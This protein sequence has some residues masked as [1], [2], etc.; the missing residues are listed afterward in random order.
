MSQGKILLVSLGP[1]AAE[2]M[3]LRARQAITEAEVV[4]GYST[5]IKLLQGKGCWKARRASAAR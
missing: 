1:G 5:Y 3:S 2:H 4:I